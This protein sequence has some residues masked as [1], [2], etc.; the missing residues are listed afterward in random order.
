M[1]KLK[2]SAGKKAHH[3]AYKAENRALKN[4]IAKLERHVLKFPGDEQS[5]A[6]LKR[7]VAKGYNRR[8]T[9]ARTKARIVFLKGEQQP[10]TLNLLN[11]RLS[12]FGRGYQGGRGELAAI[13]NRLKY[14]PKKERQAEAKAKRDDTPKQK[15]PANPMKVKK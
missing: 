6:E 13:E 5:A 12:A 2:P 15:Q 7:I 4:K 11:G 3:T 10:V 9:P 8:K 1:A 14:V